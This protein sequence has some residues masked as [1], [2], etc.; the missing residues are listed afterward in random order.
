MGNVPF[1]IGCFPHYSGF[2]F[3]QE[4]IAGIEAFLRLLPLIPAVV[5]MLNNLA[6]ATLRERESRSEIRFL[7]ID[8]TDHVL[9]FDRVFQ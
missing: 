9:I 8:Y 4:A 5:V 3:F 2:S 6:C 7:L 1:R